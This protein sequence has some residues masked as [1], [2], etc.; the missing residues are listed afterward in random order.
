MESGDLDRGRAAGAG[1]LVGHPDR[2]RH[3]RRSVILDADADHPP[4]LLRRDLTVDDGLVSARLYVTACG[5]YEAHINGRRVG[6][7]LLTPGWTSYHHRLNYQTYDVTG[8]LE[9]GGN[10]IGAY[11]ADGWYRGSYTWTRV[12]NRYGPDTALL[13]QLELR[14][15]DGRRQTVTTDGSWTWSAGPIT[16]SHLYDGERHDARLDD[17]TWSRP[18]GGGDWGPVRITDPEVRSPGRPGRA[19]GA[20][21]RAPRPG[22]RRRSRTG[23]PPA[24]FR[25]EPGRPAAHHR[26]R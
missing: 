9:P 19:A 1:G 24:R 7:D 4:V 11:L 25:A 17:P 10:A 3:G 8:L 18:G 14:Y 22:R 12:A 5:L 16:A 21:H 23:R 13:A 2:R 26:H 6:E 15:T 20:A